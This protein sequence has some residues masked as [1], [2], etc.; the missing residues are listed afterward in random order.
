MLHYLSACTG[1]ARVCHDEIRRRVVPLLIREAFAPR[2]ASSGRQVIVLIA[3]GD[4]EEKCQLGES[5]LC[6][7]RRSSSTRLCRRLTAI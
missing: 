7:S 3:Q 1:A 6:L 5:V 2:G 4:S